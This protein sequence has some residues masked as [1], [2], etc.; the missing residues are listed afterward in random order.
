MLN[1]KQALF[2]QNKL[3]SKLHFWQILLSKLFVFMAF[4]MPKIKQ[5][6]FYFILRCSENYSGIL[7]KLIMN[8]TPRIDIANINCIPRLK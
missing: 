5:N 6:H 7:L 4:M 2:P 1:N 8:N 3:N